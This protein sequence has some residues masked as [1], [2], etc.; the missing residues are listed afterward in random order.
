VACCTCH[1]HHASDIY[2]CTAQCVCCCH[3]VCRGRCACCMQSAS[4]R[5]L[6][7]L[8]TGL[9]GAW[10][11]QKL[12]VHSTASDAAHLHTCQVLH[13]PVTLDLLALPAAGGGE[14]GDAAAAPGAGT[15]AE[16]QHFALQ[17]AECAPSPPVP[18]ACT[19]QGICVLQL[20]WTSVSDQVHCSPRILCSC[21]QH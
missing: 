17:C 2:D 21:M 18:D 19:V 12:S 6:T 5:L 7:G 11:A 8:P 16:I 1:G 4:F 9:I 20:L 10:S 15:A 14:A 13:N 3:C